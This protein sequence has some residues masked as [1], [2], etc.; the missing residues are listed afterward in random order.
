MKKKNDKEID[1]VELKR[2]IQ[3][4]LYEETKGMTAE[5]KQAF[6]KKEAESG[7]MAKF[8]RSIQPKPSKKAIV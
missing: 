8:W 1:P 3:A 2:K 5:Q 7:S 6:Y 4:E